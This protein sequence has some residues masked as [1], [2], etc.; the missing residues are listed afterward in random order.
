MM[1]E[2]EIRIGNSGY[3]KEQK[4]EEDHHEEVANPSIEI[5][6][7][8]NVSDKHLA[9]TRT[10]VRRSTSRYL[11]HQQQLFDPRES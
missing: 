2:P 7:T 9:G 8:G 6:R 1:R 4:K 5:R 11:C 3:Y 10:T